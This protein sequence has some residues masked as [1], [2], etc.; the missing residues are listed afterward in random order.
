MTLPMAIDPG[1][2][3]IARVRGLAARQVIRQV[4]KRVPIDIELADGTVLSGAP[5]QE[6]T[7]GQTDALA[8]DVQPGKM[9]TL[10]PLPR[11][12]RIQVHQPRRFFS[13]VGRQAKIGIG[14]GYTEQEWGP[15]PG[16]DLA[17]VLLP[18]AERITNAIPAPLR[19]LRGLVDQPLPTA[20]RNTLSGARRNVQAHYD[21]SN[22]LFATFLDPSLSYSSALFDDSLDWRAQSLEEA[23]LRK[24]DA[25][26]D[27]AGVGEGTR[28]LEIGSGWGTLALRAAQRGASV[29]TVTLSEEQA[30]LARRRLEEAGAYA[31]PTPHS[32]ASLLVG[33]GLA[34]GGTALAELPARSTGLDELPRRGTAIA[35]RVDLRLQDYR[36]VEGE[37]D[38]IVSIEMVEAVGE[39]YWPTYFRT[40]DERLAPGGTAVVQAITLPHQRYLSTRHSYGWIQK[41]IFPGGALP[42][43][44]AVHEV[45]AGHTSLRVEHARFFG[46]HYAETLRRWRQSFLARRDEVIAL[47][48]SERFVRVWEYYL[49]YCEAGFRGG[50]IDVA[51][52]VLRR[53]N[54]VSAQVQ[55]SLG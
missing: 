44:D 41:Y 19:A 11:R 17:D 18:F 54:D 47:G 1:H 6:L 51:Q 31:A 30:A 3:L 8:Q 45:C 4:L 39:E 33:T 22:D 26:L 42:S 55:A 36:E 9:N 35:D 48:F 52:I 38:A 53:P 34:R 50:A 46:Q 21:L 27:L 32:A 7:M 29:V 5:A 23:Q 43:L 14:E 13:R 24:I 20:L 12:P 10:S 37:Y 2:G 28:L 40:L 16:H 49:A 15:A 25:A